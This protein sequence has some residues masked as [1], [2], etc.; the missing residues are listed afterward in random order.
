MVYSFI[1]AVGIFQCVGDFYNCDGQRAFDALAGEE[2]VNKF[3]FAVA[4]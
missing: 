4:D 1:F 2:A 3:D